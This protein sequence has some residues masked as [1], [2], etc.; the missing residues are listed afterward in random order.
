MKSWRQPICRPCF[1]A[2]DLGRGLAPA[3][4]LPIILADS[5]DAA[6]CLLC[7]TETRIYVQVDPKLTEGLKYA[8]EGD[9]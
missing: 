4:R 5:T 9:R 2:F 6:P 7:G 3:E 8:R 1:A